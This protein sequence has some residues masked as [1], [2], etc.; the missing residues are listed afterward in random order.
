[1]AATKRADSGEALPEFVLTDSEFELLRRLVLAQTGIALGPHKREMLKA[2]LG[3][4][5]RAL[6]LAR[7]LDYYRLLSEGDPGGEELTR[8]VNAVTTNVTDF[9]REPHHFRFLAEQWLPRLRQRAGRDGERRLRVWSAGC[10]T[11]EEPYTI[12]FTLREALGAA[13]GCW[14]VRVL[15]SD[16]DTDALARAAAGVYPAARAAT[17]PPA[18]RRRFLL[19]GTGA[20]SDLVCVRPEVRGLVAFRR[21]NLIDDPWPVH[22]SF[23]AIFCRN[24]LIY[25][26]RPTQQR[27]LER[28][29]RFLHDDGLLFLGHSESL[30]GLFAGMK[31]LENTVYQRTRSGAAGGGRDRVRAN[32]EHTHEGG[33]CPPPS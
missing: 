19:K 12:A 14:N 18:L 20:N 5:L 16:I 3:R 11:G 29:L 8:F 32:A 27:L 23:D 30:N 2:R 17:V 26:D 24:V 1:M 4:R 31:H 6:G 22:T 7:F 9:F 28:L 13:A 25:F 21:I 33:L 15:A 10:S